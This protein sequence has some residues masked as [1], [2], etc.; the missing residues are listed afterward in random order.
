[1]STSIASAAPLRRT[2]LANGLT[3]LSESMPGVRSVAF[4]A[5][6]RAASIHEPREVMGV[7]H[8]LEH[9]VFKGTSRRTAREIALSLEQLGGSLDAYTA[10]EHTSYQARVLDEHLE[11]AADVIADLV[12]DPALRA[13]DLKLERKVVLEEISMV[14]DTPDDLVFELHNEAMWG[15]HPYGYSILGTR[16]TVSRL[17]VRD[18]AALHRRAY[19]PGNIVVG[20]AGHLEHDELVETLERTGWGDPAARGESSLATV[21]PVASPPVVRHVEREGAQTHTVIGSATVRYA[22]ARRHAIVLVGVL[23]GGGMSSRL[24]QRVREELG[25]AY[26]VYGYQSFHVDTG[27]HGVYVGTAP[28]TAREATDAILEELGKVAREGLSAAD[29]ASAKSQ[30]KGQLTLSLESPSSRMYR[31]AGT[32]LY[33]EPWRSLD[34]VLALIDAISLEETAAVAE[35]FFDPARQ[36]ILSLGPTAAA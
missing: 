36:T 23:L 30:V 2:V 21:S 17:G 7:S 15:S 11:Q 32:E 24:F 12:F 4:G 6:V 33:G 19:H 26:S 25:L 9:M 5:W 31:A 18:L 29:L 27:T 22:D 28:E 14:A 8:L 35:E 20:A 13:E 34:E 1:M 3:V 10:R 16:D